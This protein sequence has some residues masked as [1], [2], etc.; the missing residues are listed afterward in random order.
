METLRLRTFLRNVFLVILMVG[1]VSCAPTTSHP[2]DE[3]EVD[4]GL[5][6]ASTAFSDGEKIPKEYTCEGN[7]ISPQLAWTDVPPATQSLVMIMDDPDAPSGTWVHWVLF[8]IEPQ[9]EELPEGGTGI[10]V[11]G[12]NSWR[13]TGYGGPCPPAGQTHRYIFKLYAL[14]VELGLRAGASKKEVEKAIQNHILAQVQIT[15]TYSR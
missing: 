9:V 10:G 4:M 5:T 2:D 15:G 3:S 6:L 1:L 7:D 14:D 11:E 8:N 13:R 12:N